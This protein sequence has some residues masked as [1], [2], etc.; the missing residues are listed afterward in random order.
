MFNVE[1]KFANHWFR[2]ANSV[3]FDDIEDCTRSAKR[4]ARRHKLM[5]RVVEWHNSRK[6]V[7]VYVRATGTVINSKG[8]VLA[9]A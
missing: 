4:T 3:V 8:N 1:V 9:A 2:Y 6:K 5:T 7:W